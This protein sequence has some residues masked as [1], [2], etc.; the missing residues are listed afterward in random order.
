M[1]VVELTSVLTPGGASQAGLAPIDLRL[2]A[3]E[4]GEVTSD[5]PDMAHTFLETLA[6]ITTP[7]SGSYTLEGAMMDPKRRAAWLRGRRR[8][9]YIGPVAAL[10]S[11]MSIREN[12]LLARSYY[13]NRLDLD[14]PDEIAAVCEE[15][16]MARKLDL[17]PGMLSPKDIRMFIAIREIMKDAAL[18][19]LDSPEDIIGHHGFDHLMKRLYEAVGSGTVM[20]FYS[21]GD[22]VLHKMTTRRFRIQNGV[23][24]EQ[25]ISLADRI[26][27]LR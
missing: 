14:L 16:G 9:G 27:A 17:R 21:G 5:S 22:N 7:V 2:S 8:I 26:E 20:V 12:L 6:L 15:L 10:I 4:V 24:E 18:L 25:T 13:E 19:V 11:N 1:T 3:G 23:L